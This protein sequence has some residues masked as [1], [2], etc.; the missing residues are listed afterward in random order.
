MS[1]VD[2]FNTTTTSI[3]AATSAPSRPTTKF[4]RR[5]LPNKFFDFRKTTL[6]EVKSTE[7]KSTDGGNM[8]LA[9]LGAGNAHQR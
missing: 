7:V 2:N 3:P 8:R 9:V 1:Q 5:P 6:S 4:A